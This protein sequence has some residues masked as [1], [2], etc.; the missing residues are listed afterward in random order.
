MN[1]SLTQINFNLQM[2]FNLRMNLTLQM[3]FNLQQIQIEFNCGSVL[4]PYNL[5][6]ILTDCCLLKVQFQKIKHHFYFE[7]DFQQ[8]AV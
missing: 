3:N 8:S 2:N 7:S 5:K 6:K 1:F 4:Y